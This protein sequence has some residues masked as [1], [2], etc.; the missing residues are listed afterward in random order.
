MK[1]VAV[2]LLVALLL[3]GCSSNQ[4]ATQ[5]AAGGTWQV[6]TLGGEGASTGFSFNTQFTVGGDGTLSIS[7]FQFINSGQPCFPIN[8]GTLSGTMVLTENT[9][10]FEVTGTF[11]Y[12]VQSGSNT[13][14]FNGT[15]TG[16]QNGLNGTTLSDAT[17]T[18]NW[19]LAGDGTNGCID[20]VGS[21]VLTQST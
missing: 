12:V 17:G 3:N 5:T 19:T 18:G 7:Y 20:T 1:E 13:L 21:F 2:L 8:G 16:T 14:T 11:S 9:T 4:T 15:V 6:Q 10:T